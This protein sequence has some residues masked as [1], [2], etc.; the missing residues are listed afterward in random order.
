[1]GINFK[2]RKGEEYEFD[3]NEE[4]EMLVEPDNSVPFPNIPA[5]APGMLTELEEEYGVDNV[6]PGKPEMSD[7]QQAILA[8]NN[9]GLDFFS[10]PTNVTGGEVIEILDDDKENVMNKLKREEVRV[11]IEPDKMDGA[12]AE[13]VSNTRRS[14][15]TRFANRQ[16]EDY[17]LYVTVKEEEQLILATVEENPADDDKDEEILADVAHF[18]MVHYEEKEGI[19]KKKKKISPS[20]GNTSWRRVFSNLVNKANQWCLKSWTSSTNTKSSNQ[21]MKM[22][23]WRRTERRCYH[24]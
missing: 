2:N 17:E 16:F 13:L 22:T 4:Y 11:K 24:C 7:K 18:I 1:M 20:L 23:C 6:V 3:N 12:T 9:S 19:K 21:N 14:G 8:A 5:V 15:R 10:V